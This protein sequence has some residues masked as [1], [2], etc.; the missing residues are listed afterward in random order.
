MIHRAAALADFFHPLCGQPGL[1][2][3]AADL[4]LSN[5]LL[6]GVVGSCGFEMPPGCEPGCSNAP[7]WSIHS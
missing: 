3:R 2:L 5:C 7:R 4:A 6:D 1:L